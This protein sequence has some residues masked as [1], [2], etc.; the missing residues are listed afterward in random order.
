MVGGKRSGRVQR[1]IAADVA[2]WKE[3]AG[4]E[5]PPLVRNCVV[6]AAM[7]W[8]PIIQTMEA[9]SPVVCNTGEFVK[10]SVKES[11]SLFLIVALA[12]EQVSYSS[13]S[14]LEPGQKGFICMDGLKLGIQLAMDLIEGGAV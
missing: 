12:R 9:G 13:I 8:L 2:H 3:A 7:K 6:T 4:L 1:P 14:K 10:H 5:W 11:R